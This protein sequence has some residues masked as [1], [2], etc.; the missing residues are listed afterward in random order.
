MEYLSQCETVCYSRRV[1]K[2]MIYLL[3]I[4]ALALSGCSTFNRDWKR[5]ANAPRSTALEGRWD[6]SWK[7]DASGHQNRLR[8]IITK[9][10]ERTYLARFHANFAKIL[11]FGYPVPLQV[12]E[13]N[14]HYKFAGEPNLGWYAGGRYTYEGSATGTNFSSTYRSKSD[15]G[16]FQ[17][18]R[19]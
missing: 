19:P 18:M 5:L 6:G 8:C 11:T 4:A 7:S 16:S 14:Q 3:G 13:K 2:T 10:N 12:Q 1:R 15:H 17:M 9:R